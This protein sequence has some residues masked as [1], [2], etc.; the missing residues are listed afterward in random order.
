[1]DFSS[2]I[3]GLSSSGANSGLKSWVDTGVNTSLSLIGRNDAKKAAD[4]DRK[5]NA[6]QAQL[7]RDFQKQERLDTQEY[8]V[9]FW[10]L[11]NQ[12]NERMLAEQREYDS[13]QAQILR[14]L[15]AGINP[16]T[17]IGG[18]DGNSANYSAASPISSSPMSGNAASY[19]SGLPSAL[20]QL[21]QNIAMQDAQIKLTNAQANKT[22]GEADFDK[23][24][25]EDRKEYVKAQLKDIYKGIDVKDTNIKVQD[26]TLDY[27]CQ[28]SDIELDTMKKQLVE[29]SNNITLQEKAI[30]RAGLENQQIQQTIDYD[31]IK[32]DFSKSTGIPIEADI[33]DTAFWLL[34]SGKINEVID[35]AYE[36]SKVIRKKA[37]EISKE[38]V[39]SLF[40]N[41]L[42]NDLFDMVFEHK[43]NLVEVFKRQRERNRKK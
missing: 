7:N 9:A 22:Q 28:K 36:S 20:T 30:E 3:S 19:T 35:S 33:Y 38:E 14:A 1:M 11:N 24:T 27:F 29:I 39:Y 5:F 6:W 43:Y 4:E 10:N 41:E 18:L 25:F 31:K 42:F 37:K 34:K 21:W 15:Q 8:N 23:A 26:K 13:P 17:V 40:D 2:I 32:L 16:N 12:Y